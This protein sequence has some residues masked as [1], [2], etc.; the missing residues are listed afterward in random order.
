MFIVKKSP[1]SLFTVRGFFYVSDNI[2]GLIV[3]D[4]QSSRFQ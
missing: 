2:N 3:G 4:E 1:R